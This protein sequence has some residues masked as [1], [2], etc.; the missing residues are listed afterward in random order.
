MV[1]ASIG[2]P[3]PPRP[4]PAF[5]RASN[6]KGGAAPHNKSTADELYMCIGVGQ[7]LSFTSPLRIHQPT[8]NIRPYI[9]SLP[10]ILAIM[11]PRHD[12]GAGQKRLQPHPD[13]SKLAQHST[14]RPW[15]IDGRSR[16]CNR[17]R[18]QLSILEPVEIC[19]C[20][21]SGCSIAELHPWLR[22][23]VN[24]IFLANLSGYWKLGHDD[25]Q[26]ISATPALLFAGR[27][28]HLRL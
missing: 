26:A 20:L 18:C 9:I 13:R 24:D 1:E 14:R 17:P 6:N 2:Q 25:N 15:S 23:L 3:G 7:T 8:M 19:L 22:S 11:N 4:F 12:R 27:S 28:E 5:T 10:A 16:S 21:Q